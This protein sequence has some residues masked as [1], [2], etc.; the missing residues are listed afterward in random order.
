MNCRARQ[1]RYLALL[2]RLFHCRVHFNSEFGSD[3]GLTLETSAFRI[4]VR[5]SIYIINSVNKTKLLYANVSRV[6]LIIFQQN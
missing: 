5:W 4:S 3:E 6:A 2:V 1:K